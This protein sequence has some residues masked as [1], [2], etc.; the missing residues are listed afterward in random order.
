MFPQVRESTI[1]VII[2]RF[3]IFDVYFSLE[4]KHD[5]ILCLVKDC[6]RLGY[7]ALL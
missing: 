2:A 7:S 1:F 4:F 5:A 3:K 6:L